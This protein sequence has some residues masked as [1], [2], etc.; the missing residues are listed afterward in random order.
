[1][2]KVQMHKSTV[3]IEVEVSTTKWVEVVCENPS[4]A[5]KQYKPSK[6]ERI[7]G[8]VAFMPKEAMSDEQL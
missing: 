5:L 6:G 4:E 2:E 1:M 8:M 7:T 3:W